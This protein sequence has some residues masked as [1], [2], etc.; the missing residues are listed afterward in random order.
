[1]AVEE[2]VFEGELCEREADDE[3]LP[4]KKRPV[5]PAGQALECISLELSSN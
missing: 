4:W 5:K 3:A 1:M 2:P